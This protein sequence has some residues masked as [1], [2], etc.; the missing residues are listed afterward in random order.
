V[1]RRFLTVPPVVAFVLTLL[2]AAPAWAQAELAVEK[3]GSPGTVVEGGEVTYTVVVRNTGDATADEVE[4]RDI[5]PAEARFISAET[6]DPN[7]NCTPPT[8]AEPDVVCDLGAIEEGESETVT[9]RARI[10]QTGTNRACAQSPS[11]VPPDTEVCDRARTRVVPDLQIDK[12]DDRDPVTVGGNIL[13]TLRIDNEG[14]GTVGQGEAIV[15]DELPIGEVRLVSVDSNAFDCDPLDPP[16]GRIRCNNSVSL[17]P[18]DIASIKITV[19]PDET[20]TISNTATVGASGVRID[21]DTETTRVLSGGGGG[22]G[23]GGNGGG[24]NGGGTGGG[25]GGTGGGGT[26]STGTGT[27]DGGG[28]IVDTTGDGVLIAS[29]DDEQYKDKVIAATIPD[30]VL[31]NT[32]GMPLLGLAAL[33]LASVVAGASVLRAGTRRRG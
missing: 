11:T 6:S 16:T 22:N 19:D 8:S 4:L 3:T 12:I 15:I 31:P 26:G 32:G 21:T 9:I 7:D 1:L 23:G 18:G 25:T 30:K 33:A 20:G 5:L 29:A 27:T 2:M 13:Y 17:G 10:R 24:G 14:A 28:L